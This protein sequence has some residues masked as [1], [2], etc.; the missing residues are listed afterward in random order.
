MNT[1]H[2]Q[3]ITQPQQLIF[4][5]GS[6]PSSESRGA[7]D[8]RGDKEEKYNHLGLIL[9]AIVVKPKGIITLLFHFCPTMRFLAGRGAAYTK[10]GESIGQKNN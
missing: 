4:N 3:R 8:R 7:W 10:A 2:R 6:R 9:V 1:K 5:L